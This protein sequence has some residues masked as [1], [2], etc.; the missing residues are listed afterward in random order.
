MSGDPGR[1]WS[2]L[3]QKER[4]ES[5]RQQLGKIFGVANIDKE[6]IQLTA[7]E[8][9]ND[10]WAGWGCPCTALTP[11]VLDNLGPDALRESAGNLHFAGTETAGEWKGYMEGAIRSGERA[12][13]EVV[14]TL[15][16]GIVSRL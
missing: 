14:K 5:L 3:S 6:F 13:A 4:E 11:G 9:V 12:A 15:N 7:Y 8:W 16:A 2:A 1:A 10:E